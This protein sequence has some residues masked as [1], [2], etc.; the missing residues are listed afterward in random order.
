MLKPG[1]MY[2]WTL[3]TDDSAIAATASEL[4]ELL[5]TAERNE[6]R[7][8]RST[9]SRQQFVIARALLKLSLSCH[10]PVPAGAWRFDRDRYRRPFI[11]APAI[12]TQVWFSV[13]HT[14]GLIA[15]LITT[16]A[17]AAVDIEKVEHNRDLVLV[18]S[19]ALSPA[20][21]KALSSLSGTD[22]TA[23]FFDHWTLKEAYA[24]ARGLGLALTFSDIGFDLEE[25]NTI[26]AHFS[27]TAG[28]NSSDW[29]FWNHQLPTQHSVS[30]A[31]KKCRGGEFD[32]VVKP[33]KFD[34]ARLAPEV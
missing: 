12:P 32:I 8:L 24:K 31:A 2:L 9:V 15:C 18:A 21:Q 23:R 28:E 11:A 7:R 30:V 25:D 17:E 10:F 19:E 1:Q 3:A 16:S 29:M 26:R 4:A 27:S 13:S 6:A 14:R 20:E 33:V 34:G 22:W 5:S